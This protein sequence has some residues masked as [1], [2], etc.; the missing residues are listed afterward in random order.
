[1]QGTAK[2]P[3]CRRY[4]T[5]YPKCPKCG[6]NDK[7]SMNGIDK[8]TQGQPRKW[9]CC[10]CK[11]GFRIEYRRRTI[12]SYFAQAYKPAKLFL[13]G[14][15]DQEVAAEMAKMSV[16]KFRRVMMALFAT[17]LPAFDE[18][19]QRDLGRN[20]K[21]LGVDITL[22]K[23]NGEKRRYLKA[24][25]NLTSDLLY[26][27]ELP[28]DDDETVKNHLEKMREELNVNPILI[29]CDLGSDILAV[30]RHVF[31]GITIQACW[32]HLH[33]WLDKELPTTNEIG[34][35]RET[36][37]LFR[38]VKLVIMMCAICVDGPTRAY[39]LEKLQ[40]IHLT[41]DRLDKK[42]RLCMAR[43]TI[44]NFIKHCNA[45]YYNT[46]D[47]LRA[48]VG[49]RAIRRL[50]YNNPVERS[51][52]DPK[53]RSKKL[54]KWLSKYD[55]AFY[56]YKLEDRLM[57]MKE[58]ASVLP[59]SNQMRQPIAHLPLSL[60]LSYVPFLEIEAVQETGHDSETILSVAE[61]TKALVIGDK[62]IGRPY[63][64]KIKRYIEKCRALSSVEN[65]SAK[66]FLPQELAARVM[67]E[68][69]FQPVLNQA[70][71]TSAAPML[72]SRLSQDTKAIE[73]LVE[74]KDLPDFAMPPYLLEARM[75]N[76]YAI[77]T[78]LYHLNDRYVTTGIIAKLL[79]KTWK[80]IDLRNVSREVT[81]TG[82]E[83]RQYMER[84]STTGRGIRLNSPGRE[85]YRTITAEKYGRFT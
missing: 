41:H 69:G 12:K 13:Y 65:I 31:P 1:M 44:D 39:V 16:R 61:A 81:S 29:V 74:H 38:Q 55:D 42:G 9:R 71:N 76:S 63:L 33:M 57:A 82:K 62:M 27:V 52:R 80:R 32:F 70:N 67:M 85:W 30:I 84:D 6:L 64:N 24:I 4:A 54:H 83:L 79:T 11:E 22:F 18:A 20:C 75:D 8:K 59:T 49:T 66:F 10:R 40:K 47:F 50:V 53:A 28:D 26:K 72:Q 73:S 48:L 68:L 34:I 77:A 2:V 45:G 14:K 3:R 56:H 17:F 5:D 25:N 35:A 43:A 21:V 51:F 36:R 78:V 7:V 46:P 60:L 58:R 19:K 23:V 15:A 37:D